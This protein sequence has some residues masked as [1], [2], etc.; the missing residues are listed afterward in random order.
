M[1][2]KG[3]I[4]HEFV[5]TVP[6]AREEGKV[7][8]SMKY[9]TAVHNCFCGCGTKV[10]TP[11]SPTGWTLTFDGETVSLDPSIG[12]WG[13]ACQSHY[14]IKRDRVNWAKP[15]S[16]DQIEGGRSYDRAAQDVYFGQQVRTPIENNKKGERAKRRPWWWPARRR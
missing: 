8:V 1:K 9:A 12:N 16:K 4:T 2:W 15:M 10:V 11:I 3:E 6:A 5:A 13:F 14:W 7:Y